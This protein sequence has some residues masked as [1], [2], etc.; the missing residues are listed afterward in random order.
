MKERATS[1][2]LKERPRIDQSKK[3]N[4]HSSKNPLIKVQPVIK[5]ENEANS[6]FRNEKKNFNYTGNH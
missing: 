1:F 4:K 2:A 6:E 3:S 5:I